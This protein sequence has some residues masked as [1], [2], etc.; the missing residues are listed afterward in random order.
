MLQ[1]QIRII[2]PTRPF[3]SIEGE[4]GVKIKRVCAYARVSTNTADQ[5]NSYRVQIE[6][7][8]G[9]IKK[10]PNWIFQGMYADE[11][12]SGTSIKNR[13]QFSKMLQDA[14]ENK[15]DLILTKS[16]SRF[17]RNTVDSL[18][19]IHELRNLGVEVFFEKE[20]LSSTDNKVDFLLTIFSSIAQEESRNISE[21][22]KW[23][24][25]K[26]YQKGEVHI[27]TK[28]FLGY[29]KDDDGVIVI[30]EEQAET[31][32]LIFNLYISGQSTR[33]I[34]NH[35][36]DNNFKNGRQEVIWK[37]ASV[38][39]ILTNEKYCGDAIL[40][41]RVTVDYLTHKSVKNTGQAPK[42]HIM[43]NHVP[44]IDRELFNAVQQIKSNRANRIEHSR[45]RNRYPLSGLVFCGEC[46]K[47]L[48]RKHYNPNTKNSRIVL[49]CKSTGASNCSNK[50]IENSL[51]E[52]ACGDAIKKLNKNTIIKDFIRILEKNLDTTKHQES[53]AGIRKQT[54]KI[55]TEIK[56]LIELRIASTD[57]IE[58]ASFKSIYNEKIVILDE[59]QKKELDLQQ[60][61]AESHL[62]RERI[63]Q[64]KN[65]LF[66]SGTILSREALVSI[67]KKIIQVNQN[68]II[69]C[70]GSEDIEQ[71]V[72]RQFIDTLYIQPSILTSSVESKG[73]KLNYRVVDVGVN[74]YEN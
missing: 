26:K 63:K 32:R 54:E 23:G 41:K 8:T 39:T 60:L 61:L 24:Y 64:I 35:L 47:K 9:R 48:N 37:P 14:R 42:Y 70:V 4:V 59:L 53:L 56:N 7:Y 21:N 57:D 25:R 66:T 3:S 55:E 11:G 43:N 45:Y 6:E 50:P 52:L 34:A 38:T 16:L 67:A 12:I 73:L 62:N 13:T 27:N 58:N 20:N 36:L 1:K 5:L 22:I 2:E 46:L 49:S 71:K 44:I 74:N 17:A 72:T 69:I 51:I 10:H 30:N 33:E 29:D 68:E 31:V 19:V 18:T 40:Q 28:R 15:I 65:F